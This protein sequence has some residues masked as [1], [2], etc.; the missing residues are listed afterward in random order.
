MPC[1]PGAGSHIWWKCE[2]ARGSQGFRGV[3]S[4]FESATIKLAGAA[5]LGGMDEEGEISML[6]QYILLTQLCC[7]IPGDGKKKIVK[8]PRLQPLLI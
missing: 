1:E 3:D 6:K 4:K 5:P 7:L 2:P 8:A